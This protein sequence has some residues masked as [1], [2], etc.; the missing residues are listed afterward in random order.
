MDNVIEFINARWKKDCDWC[1]GN[2]YWFAHILSSRF[3]FL[4]IYYLPIE[5]HFI[6]GDGNN[7]YDF[8]GKCLLN[9]M[10]YLF[11]KLKDDDPLWYNRL[12]RDCIL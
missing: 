6:A 2:C 1:S 4:Q 10:P 12:V 5:G 3:E 8:N 7:F 11:S 9:E